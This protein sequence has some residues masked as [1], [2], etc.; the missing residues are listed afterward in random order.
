MED[1]QVFR[2]GHSQLD[3]VM[4]V[5]FIIPSIGRPSIINSL[6]SLIAQSVPNWRAIVVFDG[7]DRIEGIPEDLRITTI[8]TPSKLGSSDGKL[9]GRRC[10]NA[11]E[12]R[13]Y[14]LQF[15]ETPWVAFLDDDD[16][17]TSD[18]LAILSSYLDDDPSTQ[19]L[20]FRM[21]KHSRSTY[22]PIGSNLIRR[23]EVGISFALRYDLISEKGF[24]F[25][26]GD[27]EDCDL[28]IELAASGANIQI[29]NETTYIAS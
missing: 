8:S 18:Y 12:V 28:L 1:E 15:V 25:K 10:G 29:T 17:V 13:N 16:T 9:I 20:I 6:N 21:R 24:K 7:V 3:T 23:Y 2:R 27:F 26:Q 19:V 11:G 22:P 5:T 4:E 14:A